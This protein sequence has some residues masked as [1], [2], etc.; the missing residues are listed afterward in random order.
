[1]KKVILRKCV[2]SQEMYPK[3]EL[4]RV[5]RNKDGEISIDLKGKMNGRGAYV[6]FEKK[7]VDKA[8]KTKALERALEVKIPE[9]IYEELRSLC[10]D[11]D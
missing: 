4:L 6:R 7:F 8:Q 2:A 10:I 11:V 5:V 1:M 3:R 9:E